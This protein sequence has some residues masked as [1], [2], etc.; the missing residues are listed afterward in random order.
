MKN[1]IEKFVPFQFERS[2]SD[3]DFSYTGKVWQY[4][5]CG[6]AALYHCL[7]SLGIKKKVLVPVYV[8]GSVLKPVYRLGLV[9][10]FYDCQFDDLN[11]SPSDI[12]KKIKKDRDIECV[13]VASMY[14]NP[15]MLSEIEN[16]CWAHGVK[17]IDDAAQCF[18]AVKDGRYVGTFGDAGFFSFSP[19]KATPAHLGGF[20]WTSNNNYFFKRTHHPI[21]HR[22]AFAQFRYNRQEAYKHAPS[23]LLSY[24]NALVQ[25]IFDIYND[26]MCA[27][28]KPWL[29]GCI[30][31]NCEQTYR[32]DYARDLCNCVRNRENFHIITKGGE[33]TNNHK[34]V[35]LYDN[36]KE[37]HKTISKLRDHG[38]Y[39]SNGYHLLDHNSD[40][41][42]AVRIENCVVELPL[43]ESEQQYE[44]LKRVLI[45]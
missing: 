44:Y 42:V 6:K 9:P 39:S 19:G 43:E 30:E 31:K 36:Q 25:K 32:S 17:M 29:S 37:A 35:L 3:I 27:F 5:S 24:L 33:G 4:A 40:T 10:V 23:K 38:I 26:D 12:E 13:V 28:E 45:H 21:T 11:P 1:R 20:F 22:I 7:T 14:G 34:I 15:A 16:I 41:P 2:S 8:C 18:G